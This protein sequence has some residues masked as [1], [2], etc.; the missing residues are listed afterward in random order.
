MSA[1]NIE[2]IAQLQLSPVKDSAA[3][4]VDATKVVDEKEKEGG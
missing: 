1:D 3:E 2:K 4:N